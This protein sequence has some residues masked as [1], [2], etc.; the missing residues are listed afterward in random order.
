MKNLL[1]IVFL[2]PLWS[3]SQRASGVP[4]DTGK[5]S[6]ED[7]KDI[8]LY[9]VLPVVIVILYLMWKKKQN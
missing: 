1:L 5:L 3:Y 6:L 2:I 7:P 9:I 4:G 8:V